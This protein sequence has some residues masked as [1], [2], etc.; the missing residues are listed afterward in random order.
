MTKMSA[1][2]FHY[3]YEKKQKVSNNSTCTLI[4]D[5]GQMR[6]TE[7]DQ[8]VKDKMIQQ[9]LALPSCL[10]LKERGAITEWLIFC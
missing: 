4:L 7:K 8:I 10:G 9:Y 3:V 2:T 6:K 1:K 5:T